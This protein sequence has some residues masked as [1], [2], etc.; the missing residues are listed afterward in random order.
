M[1]SM[2]RFIAVA[3][4]LLLSL[5]RVDATTQVHARATASV[6]KPAR[7][8][9]AAAPSVRLADITLRESSPR[10][11]AR[12]LVPWQP[13]RTEAG[14]TIPAAAAARLAALPE[15]ASLPIEAAH[16]LTY[17]ATAPPHLS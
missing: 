6:A 8:M 15:P 14:L 2:R 9:I 12:V 1:G 10:G 5:S 17:D 7:E 4:L 3:T 16:R 13:S 11:P